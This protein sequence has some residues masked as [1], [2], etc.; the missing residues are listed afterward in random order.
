MSVILDVSEAEARPAALSAAA[1]AA[2]A[3]GLLVVPTDT[4]YGMAARLD[5]PEALA[6]LFRVKARPIHLALPVLVAGIDQARLL[7]VM[8]SAGERLAATY[9]PGPLTIVVPRHVAMT[10]ELG[11][12]GTTVGIR[13]PGHRALLDL[14]AMTGPLATTSANLSGQPAP[15]EVGGIGEVFGEAVAVYLDGGPA[16]AVASTVV[17]LTGDGVRLIREGAIALA[18]VLRVAGTA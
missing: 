7:G 9:W 13:V 18:D 4:V 10:A 14:L 17:S 1:D 11:G 3:G 16:G 8:G 5:R 6:A 12:D 15:Q 2:A